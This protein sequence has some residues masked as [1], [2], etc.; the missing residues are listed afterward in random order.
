[1]NQVSLNGKWCL[2]QGLF[3]GGFY[4]GQVTRE[5]DGYYYCERVFC[6]EDAVWIGCV[7]F[8]PSCVKEVY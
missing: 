2:F 6:L 3:F 5:E 1:M 8:R 4:V 7:Y